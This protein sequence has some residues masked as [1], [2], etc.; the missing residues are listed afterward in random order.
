MKR[1]TALHWSV[2]H[3]IIISIILNISISFGYC[4]CCRF[5]SSL[6]ASHA[7]EFVLLLQCKYE[8]EHENHQNSITSR[9]ARALHCDRV[10][11]SEPSTEIPKFQ[12]HWTASHR[13]ALRC[14]VNALPFKCQCHYIRVR[15]VTRLASTVP[16]F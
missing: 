5:R 8:C 16:A 15:V 6:L 3:L 12:A 9:Y 4:C 14:T 11:L 2:H 13:I 10:E 7:L 1:V